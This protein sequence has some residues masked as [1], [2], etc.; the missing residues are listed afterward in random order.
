MS[1]HDN[2]LE[3]HVRDSSQ[4]R[5]YDRIETNTIVMQMKGHK[6]PPNCIAVDVDGERYL[7]HNPVAFSN[8][9]ANQ[10]KHGKV[11]K[12]PRSTYLEHSPYHQMFR[13]IT[14]EN[15]QIDE[16]KRPHLASEIRRKLQR[17]NHLFS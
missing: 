1:R 10:P 4:G 14:E 11:I 15:F 7:F 8:F 5:T 9:C 6:Q 3:E 2:V 17:S 12:N 13:F 16:E